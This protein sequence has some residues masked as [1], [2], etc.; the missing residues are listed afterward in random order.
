MARNFAGLR[1]F[2]GE[3]DVQLGL[4]ERGLRIEGKPLAIAIM[5]DGL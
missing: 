5:M 2:A 4:N 3:P 1:G